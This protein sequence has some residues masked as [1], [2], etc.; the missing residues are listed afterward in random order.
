[1]VNKAEVLMHPVRMI[2]H[3]ICEFRNLGY[4]KVKKPSQD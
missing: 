2:T 1:M 4:R 3:F